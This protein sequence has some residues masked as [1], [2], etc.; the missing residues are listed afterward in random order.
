MELGRRADRDLLRRQKDIERR[1]TGHAEECQHR[2]QRGDPVGEQCPVLPAALLRGD[3]LGDRQRVVLDDD[4]D[5]GQRKRHLVGRHLR[6]AAGDADGAVGMAAFA[7]AQRHAELAEEHEVNHQ[8]QVAG[9]AEIGEHLAAVDHRNEGQRADAAGDAEHRAEVEHDA[10]ADGGTL[11]EI[12]QDI[13]E[14]LRVGD[15]DAALYL[16]DDT[17]DERT[18]QQSVD[19]HDQQRQARNYRPCRTIPESQLQSS[20]H[21]EHGDKIHQDEQCIGLPVAVI[22]NTQ[23]CDPA[24]WLHSTAVFQNA[25]ARGLTRKPMARS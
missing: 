12:F 1:I 9:D 2:G 6:Q 10:V 11:E 4:G 3:D 25:V 22:E 16:G 14:R 17:F 15:T 19:G 5:D 21:Q 7:G 20:I 13:D 24:V 8:E 23:R 18:H